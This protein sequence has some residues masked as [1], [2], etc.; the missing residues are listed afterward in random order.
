M[1]Y[2]QGEHAVGKAGK[3][4]YNELSRPQERGIPERGIRFRSQ[5][6]TLIILGIKERI[7]EISPN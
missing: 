7:N 3:R 5:T 1:M 4:R 6:I 2:A